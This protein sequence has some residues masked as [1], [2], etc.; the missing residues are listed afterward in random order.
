MPKIIFEVNY[1]IV[2]EKRGEYLETIDKLKSL[3]RENTTP[4][5]YVMENKKISNNFSEFYM[6][7]SE[8]E[9]ES[10]EDNQD[11]ETNEL[12]EKLF[13]DYIVYNKVNYIT[14][15]EV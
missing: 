10:M 8:E 14:R 9:F 1:S 2:P 11:D 6:F 3:I 5:Y 13:N 15:Q 4:E 7:D 12:I